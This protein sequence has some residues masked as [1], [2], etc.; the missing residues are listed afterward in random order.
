MR[1]KETMRSFDSTTN[2][3]EQAERSILCLADLF[4][5]GVGRKGGITSLSFGSEFP[6]F[7]DELGN[8]IL[9]SSIELILEFSHSYDTEE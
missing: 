9:L 8:L 6:E 4:A 2:L 1:H 5:D 7:S 3:L